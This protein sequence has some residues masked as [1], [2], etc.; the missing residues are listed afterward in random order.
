MKGLF[1][2]LITT[3][4]KPRLKVYQILFFKHC[5]QTH[6]HLH[7][8]TSLQKQFD[9]VLFKLSWLIEVGGYANCLTLVKLTP[10]VSQPTPL[11]KNLVPR[12]R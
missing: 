8:H 9:E 4:V 12:F 1:Y 6:A 3:H 10:E 7:L 11:K 2:C 5:T